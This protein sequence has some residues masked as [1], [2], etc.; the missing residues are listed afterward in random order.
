MGL[1]GIIYIHANTMRSHQ[2]DRRWGSGPGC[3]HG[4]FCHCS[5]ASLHGRY[6]F[7]GYIAFV[8]AVPIK[9]GQLK[10]SSSAEERPSPVLPRA[11][12]ATLQNCCSDEREDLLCLVYQC[13]ALGSQ[14]FTGIGKQKK[15]RS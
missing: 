11:S 9:Q 2:M 14:R 10:P 3:T 13:E 8:P 6:L 5:D 15:C 12:A 4:G 7:R 1:L